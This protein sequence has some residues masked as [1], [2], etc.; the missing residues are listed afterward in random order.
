MT[1]S[2]ME[3]KDL[4]L[5]LA[6]AESE[7][8][9][10]DTLS[11]CGYWNDD[12]VWQN[13]GGNENNFATIGNQQSQPEVALVEKLINSVDA[14]LM[15]KCIESDTDLD[16]PRAPQSIREAVQRFFGI[17]NGLLQN[18]TSSSR[19][20]L[21]ENI[22]LVATGLRSN[23]C[24]SIIDRGEGQTPRNMPDTLLSIGKSNKLRIPFVQGKFNMGGTG[25]FQFCGKQNLQ[26]IISKRHPGVARTDRDSTKGL[27]GFTV[28]R[29]IDPSREVRS[30][31][32]R[33]LAP[34]SE[35]LSFEADS[36]PLLP[37]PYPIPYQESLEWGTFIKLYEYQTRHR[38][39]LQLDLYFRLSL[40]MAEVALP[41][42]LYERRAGYSA[43][44]YETTLAGL[45][46]RLADDSRDNLEPGFPTSAILRVNDQ[47]LRVDLFAFK[48]GQQEKYRK[49]EGVIFLINGQTHGHLTTSFFSRQRV[50][51]QYLSDSILVL[52]DCTGIQGR[53]REDLFMNS[54]DRLRSGELRQRIEE[55][56]QDLIK[57]HAGL[58]ELRERRRR[59]EVQHQV[60]EAGPL[61]E[62]VESVLRRIPALSKLLKSGLRIT[63]PFA[64]EEVSNSR[65]FSPRNFPTFFRLLKEYPETA[66]KPCHLSNEH[67]R[68]QFET[69]AENAYFSRDEAPGTFVLLCNGVQI[70]DFALNLW[71]GIA[72]L[73]I[74][75]PNDCE[76]SKVYKFECEVSDS[77]R[78][79]PITASFYA[80]VANP[81]ERSNG[82]AGN[83]KEG[84]TAGG[85]RRSEL[86]R[87]LEV[88]RPNLVY[89]SE[90]LQHGF[91]GNSALEVKDSG[92]GSFDFFVNADNV[93]LVSEKKSQVSVD[94]RV[95]EIR[96]AFAMTIIGLAILR[97][98]REDEARNAQVVNENDSESEYNVYADI[99]RVSSTLAPFL[100]PMVDGLSNI[101]ME[102]IAAAY[103]KEL[104]E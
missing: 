26:L 40:L 23:P 41:I 78:I 34:G 8:S 85:N 74:E 11:K 80:V 29:R 88:P 64:Q 44:T 91:D 54:R 60:N 98:H 76:I 75:L 38:T 24:F 79:D 71:N 93:Y 13:F 15:A 27:W 45:S 12:R 50:G 81:I 95:L 58:R 2:L 51:M 47:D 46:V 6:Y 53:A 21:A 103:D 67:F 84:G 61:E 83:R 97:S 48:K 18:A 102:E 57:N 63:S 25:V 96:F 90:W 9:V 35:I 5:C 49:D 89:K 69:D 70:H 77:A 65:K 3:N 33:Y 55:A 37:G 39:N 43:H 100:I 32:F 82:K 104:S 28:V 92:N 16:G 87:G 94:S 52:V 10:I 72:S 68:I 20:R 14:V 62:I 56:L 101:G 59:E 19:T 30:S 1:G 42:R 66:P 36:L 86:N 31:I 99:R 4:A 73:T 7:E 22:S 17:E